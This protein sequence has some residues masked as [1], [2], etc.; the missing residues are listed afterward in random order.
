MY[1]TVGHEFLGMQVHYQLTPEGVQQIFAEKPHV[2]R[3]FVANVP[4]VMSEKTFWQRFFTN[5]FTRQVSCLVVMHASCCMLMHS[6][7]DVCYS[8]AC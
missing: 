5:E 8:Y 6:P 2:Q 4:A 7:V 3:A 1:D